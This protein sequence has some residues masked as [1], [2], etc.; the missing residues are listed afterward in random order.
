MRATRRNADCARLECGH[1]AAPP[2]MSVRNSRRFTF[3]IGKHDGQTAG[4]IGGG[5]DAMGLR[6]ACPNSRLKRAR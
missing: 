6:P 3:Y 1:A 4:K 2:P 5:R